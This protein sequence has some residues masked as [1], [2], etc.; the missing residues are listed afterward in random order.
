MQGYDKASK[1]NKVSVSVKQKVTL[2]VSHRKK[3]LQAENY[4]FE[5]KT[6]LF[7][8]GSPKQKKFQKY[9]HKS[10]K[11]YFPG[12]L[13]ASFYHWMNKQTISEKKHLE[14]KFGHFDQN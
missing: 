3:M 13:R 14:I 4:D 10:L 2:S 5:I 7:L 11:I 9:H 1:C 12:F 6:V 8:Q